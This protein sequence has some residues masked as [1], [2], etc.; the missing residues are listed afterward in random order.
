[1]HTSTFVQTAVQGSNEIKFV[2]NGVAFYSGLVIDNVELYKI[3]GQ[4][5]EEI[6]TDD[7]QNCQCKEGYFFDGV[8]MTCRECTEVASCPVCDYD[9]Q[10]STFSCTDCF[11]GSYLNGG[12][13][14]SCDNSIADCTSCS[15]DGNSCYY[16]APNH[17]L[18]YNSASGKDSCVECTLNN[19]IVCESLNICSTC[20]E[21][22]SYFLNSSTDQC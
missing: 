15:L 16:C 3:Q 20:D 1:M 2:N 4:N 10:S 21:N 7:G 22:N 11:N 14:E 5:W 6:T 8:N 17:F 19:C 12:N 13:C 9:L 18:M